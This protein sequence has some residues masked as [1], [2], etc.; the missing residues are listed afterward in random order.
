MDA[1]DFAF[2]DVAAGDTASFS[3]A[4][5]AEDVRVFAQISGDMNPLHMDPVYAETTSFKRPVVH[6]M[7]LGSFCSALV[8]MYLPGRRCLYLSQTLAFKKPVYV[9]DVLIVRGIVTAKSVS[10]RILTITIS[11]ARGV[12]EVVT[13]VATVQVLQ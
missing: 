5:S 9:G 2:E 12:E 7:L 8:G 13:G 11:I 3:R 1:R 10:T 6:G 4:V